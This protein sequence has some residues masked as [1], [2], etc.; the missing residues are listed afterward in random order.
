MKISVLLLFFFLICH[1]GFSQRVSSSKIYT[2]ADTLRGSIT[3]ERAWWDVLRYDIIIKP[4]YL[5][6]TTAGKNRITYKVTTERHPAIMQVD[7]QTPLHIDSIVDTNG[8]MLSFKREG[9]AWYV[10]VPEQ[11]KFSTNHVDI[12]FS[13]EPKQARNPPW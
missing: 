1:R 13:G 9:N 7:L 8:K 2:H 3:A 5:K 10:S 11:N 4:D 12:Y 6:K